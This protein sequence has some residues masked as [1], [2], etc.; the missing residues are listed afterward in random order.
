[1]AES[2]TDRMH[3]EHS[4][5]ITKL[6]EGY[7][8]LSQM[9][10]RNH[11]SAM[12]RIQEHREFVNEKMDEQ[13]RVQAEADFVLEKKIEKNH[14]T[15]SLQLKETNSTLAQINYKLGLH[16]FIFALMSAIGTVIGAAFAKSVFD[17][18]FR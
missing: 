9:L 1:M 17:S 5:R 12:R 6:E 3:R 16:T 15:T 11:S 10:K 4:E 13:V 18:L 14:E 2:E 7:Q 8:Y